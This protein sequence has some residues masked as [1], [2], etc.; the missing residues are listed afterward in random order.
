MTDL[1]NN[2]ALTPIDERDG[3]AGFEDDV[4]GTEQTES[5][6]VIRGV[7]VKFTNEATWVTSDGEELPLTLEPIVVDIARVVQRWKDQRPI[8][9]MVLAP[10]QK[11]PDIKA[12]N[13]EVP[14]KEWEEGPDGKPRGPW[15][16]QFIVYLLNQETMDRYTF[17]T[18]TT[19]GAIAVRDLVD[20]TVWMRR[21]RGPSV[22]PVVRLKDVFMRTRFGGRQRPHFEIVRWVKLG[23]DGTALPVADTPAAL[24]SP[25]LGPDVVRD[26]A[27]QVKPVTA[28]EAVD[29]EIAY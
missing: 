9:T 5:R 18:G 4:E 3:F 13:A 26:P 27:L 25:H 19:G 6:G 1:K 15:Q 16:A 12:L 11:I 17:P 23:D 7:C 22:F 20:R 10:G 14:Q 8:E 2:T 21:F 29:D 24:P 28:S